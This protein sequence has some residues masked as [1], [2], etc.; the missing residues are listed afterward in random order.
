MPLHYTNPADWGRCA[1]TD[2][3]L[4]IQQFKAENPEA[5][6]EEIDKFILTLYGVNEQDQV[7]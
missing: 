4:M 7:K 1:F 6:K 3:S 2:K 5:T